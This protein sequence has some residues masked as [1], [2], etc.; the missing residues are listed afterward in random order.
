[1]PKAL[2]AHLSCPAFAFTPATW[3]FCCS[4]QCATALLPPSQVLEEGSLQ[5]ADLQAF[6]QGWA[7]RERLQRAYD[8]PDSSDDM[9]LH[10]LAAYCHL[11]GPNMPVPGGYQVGGRGGG[12]GA[13][14][15]AKLGQSSDPCVQLVSWL[16]GMPV[17]SADMWSVARACWAA[18]LLHGAPLPCL[19]P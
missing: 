1:M 15:A 12:G 11:P 10:W 17:Q 19:H 5:G 3:P 13:E 6:C 14:S 18:V 16:T 7:L 9:S 8:G 4:G 2:C